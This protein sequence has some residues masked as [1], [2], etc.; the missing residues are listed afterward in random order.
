MEERGRQ[1]DAAILLEDEPGA[2][3]HRDGRVE[4]AREELR[5]V[6][7]GVV[8]RR[9]AH[10]LVASGSQDLGCGDRLREMPAS[11]PLNREKDSQ[12]TTAPASGATNGTAR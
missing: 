6:T 7:A 11:L 5:Q 10:D 12:K 9:H 4:C 1:I 2:R 3:Q 8:T